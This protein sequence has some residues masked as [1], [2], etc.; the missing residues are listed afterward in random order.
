M[1]AA[2]NCEAPA[3]TT[4][5]NTTAS[6]GEKPLARAVSPKTTPNPAA[7]AMIPRRVDDQFNAAR[8]GA[9]RGPARPSEGRSPSWWSDALGRRR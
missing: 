1:P 9:G 8:G 2:A 7:D 5:E 4:S 3:K 6:S